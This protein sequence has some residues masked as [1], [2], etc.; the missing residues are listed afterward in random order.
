[1]SIYG[2]HNFVLVVNAI[3]VGSE[4]HFDRFQILLSNMSATSLA[5]NFTRQNG[6]K[7]ARLLNC[8]V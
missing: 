4:I 3:L 6:E 7:L 8:P 1:M 5:I 2:S